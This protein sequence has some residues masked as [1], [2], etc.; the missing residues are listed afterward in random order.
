MRIATIS[1]V[2]AC[3]GVSIAG[4]D[5]QTTRYV[6]DEVTPPDSHGIVVRDI[7]DAGIMVGSAPGA[8]QLGGAA[9]W[10]DGPANPPVNLDPDVEQ[11]AAVALNE[12][13]AV[14]GSLHEA[15]AA[16]FLITPGGPVSMKLP[17]LGGCCGGA[18]DINE[19]GVL[20][21]SGF[22]SDGTTPIHAAKWVDGVITDLGVLADGGTSEA[23]GI[24]DLGAIVGE[25]SDA[26]GRSRVLIFDDAGITILPDLGGQINMALAVNNDMT[27][28]G[29]VGKASSF[30]PV[31]ALWIDQQLTV[32]P[33]PDGA[34]GEAFDIN[35]A[36]AIV[37][38]IGTTVRG[39]L[40]SRATLWRNGQRHD[41][42]EL[43][44]N[45]PADWVLRRAAAINN[46]G[47]IVG[48]AL[49]ESTF[50]QPDYVL[51]PWTIGDL[52][53]NHRVDVFDLLALLNAWGTCA[54][55][56][57]EDFNDDGAVN[58]FD[59]LMLLENWR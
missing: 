6:L 19:D 47:Q 44:V 24:N 57:I 7:N 36:G 28:V 55:Q 59:L 1:M 39:G 46:N 42:N 15:V 2:A 41:L 52:D 8:A 12:Q 34:T 58:V 20:V 22:T 49:N 35:E 40:G 9:A 25:G 17:T 16:L 50:Q 54:D 45:M 31:P 26:T 29:R 18:N 27:I 13:G 53:F 23:H 10:L 56:C 32:L 51:T 33:L 48:S 30:D 43:V 21:G 5:A 38:R 14:A 37:G 3:S 11:S 4:V